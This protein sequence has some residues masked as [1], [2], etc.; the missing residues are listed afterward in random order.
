MIFRF[1]IREL[2]KHRLITRMNLLLIIMT[3]VTGIFCVSIILYQ[4]RFYHAVD[5]LTDSQGVFVLTEGLMTDD[6][7]DYVKN[8]EELENLLP[9]ITVSSFRYGSMQCSINSQQSDSYQNIIYDDKIVRAF[10]PQLEEGS[11]FTADSSDTQIEAVVSASTKGIHVGDKLKIMEDKNQIGEVV[12][13]GVLKDGAEAIGRSNNFDAITGF[14]Y[15]NM[16]ANYSAENEK[17]TIFL[18]QSNLNKVQKS[19]GKELIASELTGGIFIQYKNEFTDEEKEDCYSYVSSHII[20]G[21]DQLINFSDIHQNSKAYFRDI[22]MQQVPIFLCVFI[23]TVI[24]VIC[25]EIISFKMSLRDF[26]IYCICGCS[27]RD[28]QMIQVF[29]IM[30]L[31]VLSFFISGLFI[32]YCTWAKF[33][34]GGV[35]WIGAYQIIYCLLVALIML[36][37]SSWIPAYL[38][39]KSSSNELLRLTSDRK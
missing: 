6:G 37:I 15:R 36:G 8:N 10:T 16:Y 9:G 33:I 32:W 17:P 25:I 7:S 19:Q 11:W 20:A 35:I 34:D 21:G 39:K 12:V 5:T 4:Y 13:I 23:V 28:I 38:W 18:S 26:A 2:G 27:K 1:G 22:I 24:S 14:S 29:E 31:T 3:F 30:I